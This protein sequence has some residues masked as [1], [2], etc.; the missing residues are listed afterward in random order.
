MVVINVLM[1]EPRLLVG[2]SSVN[3]HRFHCRNILL[4]CAEAAD[5]WK[6]L[7]GQRCVRSFTAAPERS[8]NTGLAQTIQT[9]Q[10][11]LAILRSRFAFPSRT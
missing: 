6:A 4:F 2:A 11:L 1:K 7:T 9:V 5:R 8:N 3:K 10:G